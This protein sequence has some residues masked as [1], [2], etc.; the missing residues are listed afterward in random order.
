VRQV[1]RADGRVEELTRPVTIGEVAFLI[2][3]V[4][5]GLDTVS[6]RRDGLVMLVDDLGHDKGSPINEAATKL[7]RSVC[8]PGTTH[9]IRGDVV[10]TFD[11][12]FAGGA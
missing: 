4:D 5:S 6:L 8:V 2:G 10:V 12:D 1:L 9:V 11:N 3:A 7:Y